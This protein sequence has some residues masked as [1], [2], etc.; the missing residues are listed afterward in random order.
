MRKIIHID[1]DAFYAS[2]E[3]HDHP[4]LLG[5]PIAV[6]GSEHRG[7]VCA[8][9][10]EARRF[11]VRSAMTGALA[12]KRCPHITFVAPRFPR[13]KEVSQ[14]I[15]AIFH[16]Y[17]DCIEPISLDEAFL[18]VTENKIGEPLAVEIARQIRRRIRD[19]LGLTASAGVSYNK[20][21]AK[22]ASDARKPDGLCTVHPDQALDFIAALPIEAFWGVGRATAKRMHELGISTG[23]DLRERSL[24]EL[25]RRFGKSGQVFYDFARGIDDRPVVSE[26]VR[27]SFGCEHTFDEDSAEPLEVEARLR[28]VAEELQR[29]L[30]RKGFVGRTLTL[31][32][33]FSDF[34]SLTRSTSDLEPISSLERILR[35]G[36]RLLRGLDYSARPIRLLGLSLSNPP[37]EQRPGM[38]VPQWLPL[39]DA[40][41]RPIIF[42]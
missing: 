17:T 3:Q 30:E 38:W 42:D 33:K 6:G 37:E 25:R 11:G 15:H 19:E 1:M 31:K 10:Y 39:V 12:R 18:D 26:W 22:V 20:F 5:K 29:R 21:L 36:L 27:K 7:V 14:A 16:D 28:L 13:Y 40:E 35:L 41:G 34:S 8:A 2:V 9:S 23:A 4:E 24:E 32:V